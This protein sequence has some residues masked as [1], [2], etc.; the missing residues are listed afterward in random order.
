MNKPAL[1]TVVGLIV[2]ALLVLVWKAW[3]AGTKLREIAGLQ[4]CQLLPRKQE[5]QVFGGLISAY[6]FAKDRRANKV[7]LEEM[8]QRGVQAY[9]IGNNEVVKLAVEFMN[10]MVRGS[11]RPCKRKRGVKP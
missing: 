6:I 3:D 7:P 1:L 9:L 5:S 10:G 4:G 8:Y 11:S 2:I